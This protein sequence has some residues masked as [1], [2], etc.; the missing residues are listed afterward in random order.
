MRQ[1]FY[2]FSIGRFHMSFLSF[3][4]TMF[5]FGRGTVKC[6]EWQDQMFNNKGYL[7]VT[8]NSGADLAHP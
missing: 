4:F 2:L 7:Q 5:Y 3:T 6:C 1:H 8:Q